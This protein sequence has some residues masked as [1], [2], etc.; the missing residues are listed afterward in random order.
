MMPPRLRRSLAVFL[1]LKSVVWS[2]VQGWSFVD[3][4]HA[5][6]GQFNAV[7]IVDK[8]VENGVGIGGIADDLMPAIDGKL[9]GDHRRFAAIAFFED[10]Q[11]IM[12]RGGVE[13]SLWLA[14]YLA[15][16]G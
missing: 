1:W 3:A 6:T 13:K 16:I 9:R 14:A 2:R 7:G 10:F 5:F 11:K 8:P 12:A 15:G 4:A